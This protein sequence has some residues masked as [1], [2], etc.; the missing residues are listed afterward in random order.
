MQRL[1]ACINCFCG[2][3][4]LQLKVSFTAQPFWGKKVGFHHIPIAMFKPSHLSTAGAL[5]LVN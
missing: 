4:I 3:E 2:S 1:K 5:Y